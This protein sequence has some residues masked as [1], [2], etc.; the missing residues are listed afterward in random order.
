[1]LCG[2]FPYGLAVIGVEWIEGMPLLLVRPDARRE[3]IGR[4]VAEAE[5]VQFDEPLPAKVLEAVADALRRWPQVQLYV[6]GHYGME[7]DGG[8]EFLRGFEHV[9]RL[10]LNLLG[11]TGVDG[12][13]R[14]TA[15]RSLSLGGMVKRNVSVAAIAHASGL[16]R[17][18]VDGGMR[19]LQVIRDLVELKELHSP[20]TAE[21]VESVEGH[22]SLR[23]LS[24]HFGS[25]RDLSP[26]ESCPQLTDIEIWQIQKLT[27]ADLKP[28]A[29]VPNLDALALGALRNV[30]TMSWLDEGRRRLRFLTLERL[31][32]LDSFEP[33]RRCSEL[34]AFGACDSRPA[35]R[36]LTPLHKLPLADVAC[37]DVYPADEIAALLERCHARVRIRGAQSSRERSELHW[38]MLF[39]YADWYRRQNGETG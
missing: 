28:V 5:V 18:V 29:R 11:L 37:C 7:L 22:P 38:R 3:D 24:L 6:Y 8:L 2:E 9:E 16:Q 10:S 27:A 39:E 30:T 20:A 4:L 36:S 34:V 19:D 21:A 23:R 25:H 35:D 17:L 13:A 31:P 1:M 14:F 33:L 15:L 32:G 12:L 26:L